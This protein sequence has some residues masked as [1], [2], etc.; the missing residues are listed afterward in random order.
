MS[1]F[2]YWYYNTTGTRVQCTRVRTRVLE[3]CTYIHTYARTRV[4]TYVPGTC[5]H[6]VDVLVTG[7]IGL[8]PREPAAHVQWLRDHVLSSQSMCTI[9]GRVVS[10][11]RINDFCC[12]IYACAPLHYAH[13]HGSFIIIVLSSLGPMYRPVSYQP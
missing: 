6:L 2:A 7:I 10:A 9:T 12:R 4:R 5:V 3:T 11:R 13:V 8:G 1:L